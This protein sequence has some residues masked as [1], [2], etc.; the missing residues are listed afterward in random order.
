MN[1]TLNIWFNTEEK[2][3]YQYHGKLKGIKEKW[4]QKFMILVL[5]A[6]YGKCLC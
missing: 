5:R 3:V 6:H 1:F 4:N 2:R